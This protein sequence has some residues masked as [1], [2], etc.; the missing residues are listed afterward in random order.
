VT[1]TLVAWF[2]QSNAASVSNVPALLSFW[3]VDAGQVNY[4]AEDGGV[5]YESGGW[6]PLDIYDAGGVKAPGD[7]ALVKLLRSKGIPAA[8]VR[9]T[10]GS[11]TIFSDWNASNPGG[12]ELYPIFRDKVLAALADPALPI[13]PR[14]R[15]LLVGVGGE[16]DSTNATWAADFE[17][18]LLDFI[19][20]FK[21]DMG[22]RTVEAI[23][24]KLHPDNTLG[25]HTVTIRAGFDA[26]A[27]SRSWFRTYEPGYT[28]LNADSVHE[29]PQALQSIG[30]GVAEIY[31]PNPRS[32]LAITS[33]S[34]AKSWDG[35]AGTGPAGSATMSG[36]AYVQKTIA[37]SLVREHQLYQRWVT[38]TD[39]FRFLLRDPSGGGNARITLTAVNGTPANVSGNAIATLQQNV[40]HQVGFVMTG[41]SMQ[42]YFDGVA[43]GTPTAIV[44]YTAAA[45]GTPPRIGR[46]TSGT[47]DEFDILAVV[48]ANATAWSEADFAAGLVNAK[49]GDYSMPSATHLWNAQEAGGQWHDRIAKVRLT[50]NGAPTLKLLTPPVWAA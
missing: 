28:Q 36:V 37:G 43:T 33:C 14:A 40:V 9:V 35:S 13:S 39:G 6:I 15:I 4:R 12:A 48:I 20:T 29:P 27:A 5:V 7:I 8:S 30:A 3:P 45:A 32:A 34:N 50:I 31:A 44:G 11:T 25:A 17:E 19:D 16:S 41:G 23:F 49:L 38:A 2:W 26:V 47:D 1:D 46:L 21:A 18:N 22:G 10:Q 24:P 42:F